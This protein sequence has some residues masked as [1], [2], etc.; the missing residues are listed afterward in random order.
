[1]TPVRRPIVPVAALAFALALGCGGGS[2][3]QPLDMGGPDG[4]KISALIEDVNDAVGSPKK[5]D[6]LFAKGAKPADQKKFAKCAYSIVGRPS[7]SGGTATAKV[8]VDPASGG[9]KLGEVEWTFE[10]D[11]DKWKI[12]TAPLP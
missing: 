12:K 5:Q 1:M 2:D 8:R 4:D 10:K 3:G 11:G 9:E 7:V 6:L